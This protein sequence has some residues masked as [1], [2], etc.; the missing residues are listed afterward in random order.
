V[1]DV[2]KGDGPSTVG[3]DFDEYAPSLRAFHRRTR[4]GHLHVMAE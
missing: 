1:L 4:V 3:A 2:T